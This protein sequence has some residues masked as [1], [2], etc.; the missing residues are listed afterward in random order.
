MPKVAVI[1]PSYRHAA[2]LHWRIDTIL[3]QTYPDFELL[4][5]DD[6]SP[7]N[8]REIIESYRDRQRVRI[9]H[10]QENSGS[11]FRQ[12]EKGI[13][14]TDSDYVWI[15][16]SDDW[17]DVKYLE[18]MVP[19]LD[20]HPAVGMAYCQ[21]WLVNR[22]SE[23]NGHASCW[24]EDLDAERWKRD[25]IAAGREEIRRSL[26]VKNTIPNASA[27]LMRRKVLAKTLPIDTS[28]QLCGDWMHWMRML[29][30]ADV[31][32][33]AEN[34][35]YWRLQSSNART[36]APGVLEWQE[37]ERI[38]TWACNQLHLSEGERDS[39]LLTFFQKCQMWLSESATHAI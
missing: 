20:R 14:A 5:L 10:N 23:I 25:F 8:S 15:A 11:V 1:V 3:D 22:E 35:N 16:E 29:A 39:V 34:L 7:D 31:A 36:A 26:L 17:A 27:V 12:W 28:F 21:S 32:F 4:I 38:L 18:R 33:V 24:T 9:L 6:A 2:Y 13:N 19:V 37:G 30:E